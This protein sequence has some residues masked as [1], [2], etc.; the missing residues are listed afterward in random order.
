MPQRWLLALLCDFHEAN[1]ISHHGEISAGKLLDPEMM[2][3]PWQS[4]QNAEEACD[5]N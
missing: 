4:Q 1:L 3:K 5:L 2:E